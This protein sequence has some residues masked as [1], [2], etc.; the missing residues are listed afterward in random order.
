MQRDWLGK[1]APPNTRKW[2]GAEEESA[3]KEEEI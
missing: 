3:R 2:S 1:A